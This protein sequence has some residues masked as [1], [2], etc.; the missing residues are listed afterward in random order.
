MPTRRK[1]EPIAILA[2][3]LLNRKQEQ[4]PH[5]RFL[6]GITGPPGA[7]KSTLA[8]NLQRELSR[9]AT[10]S[11][12]VPMD[13]YHLD[14][15]TLLAMGIHHLKGIEQSFDGE[16]FVQLLIRLKEETD[17]DIRYPTFDRS[18]ESTVSGGGLVQ[19]AEKLLIVEGNYLLSEN[20]PW[21]QIRCRLDWIWYVDVP[22]DVLLP[23]LLERHMSGG[24]N[25]EQA[26]EKVNSTDMPNAH[27]IAATKLNAD[28][29]LHL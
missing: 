19:S 9:L 4:L 12:V 10:P 11:A 28:I 5:D 27:H 23:R 7:G 18:T 8:S 13:G 21:Y 6:L 25:R 2:Q 24:K 14:N 16:G 3:E 22:D 1:I 20:L 29:I 26:L 17:S 15:E